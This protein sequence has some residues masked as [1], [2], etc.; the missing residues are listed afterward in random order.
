MTV[1]SEQVAHSDLV[2]GTQITLHSHA[3]GGLPDLVVTKNSTAVNAAIVD[4][5]CSVV[6]GVFKINGII[7]LTLAGTSVLQI[8]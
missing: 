7:A 4:G 6:A 1:Q 2:G 5:Y 8:T 3:G